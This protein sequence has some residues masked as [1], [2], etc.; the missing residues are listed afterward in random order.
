MTT[1][2]S[3]CVIACLCFAILALSA[4]GSAGPPPDLYVL[5]GAAPVG[6]GPV[7]RPGGPVVQLEPVR[8]PDYL[9]TTDI[10]TRGDGGR[11]VASRSGRWGERLSLGVTRAVAASLGPRLSRLIVT[12]SR[13]LD[14]PRWQVLI[15]VDAFDVRPGA[16]C[17]LM[18]RWS[19]WAGGGGP[20]LQ[21]ERFSLTGRVESGGDPE[22]VAVMTRELDELAALIAPALERGEE[23]L[24]GGDGSPNDH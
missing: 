2:H 23:R 22:V 3:T 5:G 10:L 9:D 11:I 14:T 1:Q 21:E 8:I 15:D 24:T 17:V 20:K 6:A 4:C 16:Q 7:V 13:P 19:I 18:G 12:T